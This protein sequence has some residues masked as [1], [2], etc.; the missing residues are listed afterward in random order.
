MV[1]TLA[2]KKHRTLHDLETD[3]SMVRPFHHSTSLDEISPLQIPIFQ[4]DP[5]GSSRRQ[6]YIMGARNWCSV[7][8]DRAT[9]DLIFD[10]HVEKEKGHG[11]TTG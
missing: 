5:D 7:D 6:K 8:F 9:G 2:T 4:K 10:I 1:S 3:E 11:E